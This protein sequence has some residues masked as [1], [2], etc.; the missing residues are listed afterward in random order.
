MS[1]IVC[2]T[3]NEIFSYYLFTPAISLQSTLYIKEIGPKVVHLSGL[4]TCLLCH[5][6]GREFHEG[7]GCR[8]GVGRTV[9]IFRSVPATHSVRGRTYDKWT[10]EFNTSDMERTFA[11]Y[12][13]LSRTWNTSSPVS[14]MRDLF[15]FEHY[16]F[17]HKIHPL[18][19][20]NL[21][22][23]TWK[24]DERRKVGNGNEDTPSK[25]EPRLQCHLE[26]LLS[27]KLDKRRM[28]GL[29]RSLV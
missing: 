14:P 13:P 18:K 2:L 29:V 27:L 20:F 1:V 25:I 15:H 10:K 22:S 3:F 23:V 8:S 6:V 28:S 11:S 17:I 5:S 26:H 12:L 21:P 4:R 24:D 9:R 7:D 19:S 16:R